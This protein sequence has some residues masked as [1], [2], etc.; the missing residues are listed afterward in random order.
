[1]SRCP[2][3]YSM[4]YS[5]IVFR[6][7]SPVVALDTKDFGVAYEVPP[8]QFEHQ[9]TKNHVARLILIPFLV[10]K[11][12]ESCNSVVSGCKMLQVFVNICKFLRTVH[13]LPLFQVRFDLKEAAFATWMAAAE[14]KTPF[15][16][17]VA[18]AKKEVVFLGEQ[19]LKPHTAQGKISIQRFVRNMVDDF[20]SIFHKLVHDD[21]IVVTLPSTKKKQEV[22]FSDLVTRTPSYFMKR[23]E[24]ANLSK[25]EKNVPC[26]PQ[27]FPEFSRYFLFFLHLFGTTF[28]W[29]GQE[30]K[31]K[32]PRKKTMKINSEEM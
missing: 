25:S 32:K 14:A 18:A 27:I 9:I 26:Q 23:F 19:D 5:R 28:L 3:F 15:K 21:S 4:N 12:A 10:A 11:N 31:E 20:E 30:R 13:Y 16:P 22:S 6:S 17:A 24:K 8:E 29:T 2:T 7:S 1:M